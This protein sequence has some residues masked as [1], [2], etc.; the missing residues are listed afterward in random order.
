MTENLSPGQAIRTRRVE[1]TLDISK[2]ARAAGM[3]RSS[4][5]EIET[6]RRWNPQ[7]VT[8][9]QFDA[10]LQWE[11]GTTWRLFHGDPPVV[12]ISPPARMPSVPPGKRL[13]RTYH[14]TVEE[15][16]HPEPPTD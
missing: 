9:R 7:P 11:P 3:S 16:E 2:A 10:V 5:H 15:Y 12:T 8:C 4:W 1:L 14:I 6:D 13:V